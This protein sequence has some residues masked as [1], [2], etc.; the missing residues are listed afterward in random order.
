[1]TNN[2]SASVPRNQA[3]AMAAW[4]PYA[5]QLIL[6]QVGHPGVPSRLQTERVTEKRSPIAR[7]EIFQFRSRILP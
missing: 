2:R 4:T 5:G 1:M 6:P 3:D 7:F